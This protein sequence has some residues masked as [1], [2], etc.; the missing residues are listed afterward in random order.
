MRAETGPGLQFEAKRQGCTNT[1]SDPAFIFKFDILFIVDFFG[2]NF[3]FFLNI[4]LQN[5]LFF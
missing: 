3:V 2:I 5:Y 1:W 4:A